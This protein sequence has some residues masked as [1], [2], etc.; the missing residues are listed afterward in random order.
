MCWLLF[1][2]CIYLII[3]VIIYFTNESLI[4][5][6]LIFHEFIPCCPP[7]SV[8]YINILVSKRCSITRWWW[9]TV[10][11]SDLSKYCYSK[12]IFVLNTGY[13]SGS[14]ILLWIF[15]FH[16]HLFFLSMFFFFKEVYNEA[17]IACPFLLSSKFIHLER[18]NIKL[19]FETLNNSHLG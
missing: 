15:E 3:C 11:I 2:T 17:D 9:C 13:C 16:G 10:S 5:K 8:E 6:T 7:R 19:R 14:W 18:G 1:L 12:W 4:R